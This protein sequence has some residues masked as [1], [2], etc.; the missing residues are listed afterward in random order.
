MPHICGHGVEHVAA[1]VIA[2]KSNGEGE[3]GALAQHAAKPLVDAVTGRSVKLPK[4][5]RQSDRLSAWGLATDAGYQ[6]KNVMS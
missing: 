1:F 5:A 6:F 3:H 4:M 2:H